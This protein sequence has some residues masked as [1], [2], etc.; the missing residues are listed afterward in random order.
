MFLWLNPLRFYSVYHILYPED[1][2]FFLYIGT[3]V[4]S[5]EKILLIWGDASHSHHFNRNKHSSNYAGREML[6]SEED[7]CITELLHR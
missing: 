6:L 7:A 5:D 3:I 1:E 2:I 4:S